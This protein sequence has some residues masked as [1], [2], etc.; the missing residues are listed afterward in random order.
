M[1]FGSEKEVLRLSKRKINIV[2]YCIL[3]VF[4]AAMYFY[5]IPN[6]VKVRSNTDIGPEVFPKLIVLVLFALCVIGLIQEIWGMVQEHE[7]WQGFS[8]SWKAYLPQ[9]G[10]IL[11]GVIFLF[12]AP[13]LGFAVAAIPFMFFLLNYFGSK[14]L[15]LNLVLSVVYP[16]FLFLLFSRVLHISFPAGIFGF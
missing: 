3:L 9:V 2:A 10:M 5:V 12:L 14:R 13:R 6:Y 7:S 16:V 15:V 4:C 1:V 11:S 8:I